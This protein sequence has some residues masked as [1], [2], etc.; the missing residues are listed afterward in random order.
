MLPHAFSLYTAPRHPADEFLAAHTRVNVPF[1]DAPIPVA[2]FSFCFACCSS[3]LLVVVVLLSYFPHSVK[4]LPDLV[5]Q[6]AVP[7]KVVA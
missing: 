1:H 2:L 3:A 6:D 7:T 4:V 5:R